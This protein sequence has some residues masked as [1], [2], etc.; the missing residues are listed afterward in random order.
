MGSQATEKGRAYEA[1]TMPGQPKASKLHV[2]GPMDE[3][4]KHCVHEEYQ[5]L[6]WP[7]RVHLTSCA[8]KC[9]PVHWVICTLS[10][11]YAKYTH[12]PTCTR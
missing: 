6:F 9:T 12:F 11:R 1:L 7:P 2:K 10:V 3:K 5:D 8:C 4:T